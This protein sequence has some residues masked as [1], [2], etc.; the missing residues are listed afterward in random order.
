M[1]TS[2]SSEEFSFVFSGF[3]ATAAAVVAI[4]C[5]VSISTVAAAT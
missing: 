1:A 3:E 2:S 4:A 5:E